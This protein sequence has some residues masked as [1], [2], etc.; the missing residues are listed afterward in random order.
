MTPEQAKVLQRIIWSG[1]RS[2]FTI[3]LAKRV[4]QELLGPS[5]GL[6]PQGEVRGRLAYRAIISLAEEAWLQSGG[7]DFEHGDETILA[8]IYLGSSD[9]Q[10]IRQDALTRTFDRWSEDRRDE[11]DPDEWVRA[12][13]PSVV[14]RAFE[15]ATEQ[16]TDCFLRYGRNRHEWLDR[17]EAQTG[18]PTGYR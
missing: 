9:L 6:T 10:R 5:L 11:E 7:S 15:L 13:D 1:R 12:L 4:R 18:Q 2:S 16:V 14:Q 8:A 17:I 3:R